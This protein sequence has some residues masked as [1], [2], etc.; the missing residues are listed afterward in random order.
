MT[1]VDLIAAAIDMLDH[2]ITVWPEDPAA[3]QASFAAANALLD[4]DQFARDPAAFR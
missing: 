3:D 1:R 4:L 2:F